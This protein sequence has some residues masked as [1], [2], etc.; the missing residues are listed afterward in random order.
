MADRPRPICPHET[1]LARIH[2]RYLRA[3]LNAPLAHTAHCTLPIAHCTH[4]TAHCTLHTAHCTLYA[5]NT[6]VENAVPTEHSLKVCRAQKC[7]T[8]FHLHAFLIMVHLES[9]LGIIVIYV[10][11]ADSPNLNVTRNRPNLRDRPRTIPVL[12][13]AIKSPGVEARRGRVH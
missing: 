2:G 7:N 9:K 10:V 1:P 5:N 13:P 8:T 3:C 12:A 6:A 4:H 11:R